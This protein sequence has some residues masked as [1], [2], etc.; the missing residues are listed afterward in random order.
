[1]LRVP[2]RKRIVR[3]MIGLG[4]T[5]VRIVVAIFTMAMV[6]ASFCST[7]C[8]VGVCPNQEQQ[9][10]SHDC[11]H[12]SPNH[13]SSPRHQGPG[14]PDC[15]VHHHPAVNLVKAE[16][17]PRFR[18]TNTGQ[19]ALNKLLYKLL[20]DSSAPILNASSLSD[21]APPKDPLYQRISV[22]RI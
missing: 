16:G 8:A 22:L 15:S 3:P 18:P 4:K 6:Y 12:P 5:R 1:M 17:L 13:S 14:K 11:D 19:I 7:T 10:S 21:L 9:S 2:I 20:P